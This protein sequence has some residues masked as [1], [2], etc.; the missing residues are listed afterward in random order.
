MRDQSNIAATRSS[1]FS[2]SRQL[3]TIGVALI[4]ITLFGAAVT[5]WDLRREAIEDYR[6]HMASLGVVLAEQTARYVQVVDLA[7]QDVA[8]RSAALG[9]ATPEQFVR[10]L[11]DERSHAFLRGRVNN[12]PQTGA[13]IL[14]DA[15]GKLL[16]HSY[17]QSI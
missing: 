6:Q 7:L 15:F 3:W 1:V 5:I 13:I 10:Q 12:L 14:I 16:N 17:D 11:G 8:A 2:T 9:I 4:V